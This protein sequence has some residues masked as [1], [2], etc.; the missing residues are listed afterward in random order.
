MLDYKFISRRRVLTLYP[1][2][3]T[4]SRRRKNFRR[5][6]RY[7]EGFGLVCL[8]VRSKAPKGILLESRKCFVFVFVFVRPSKNISLCSVMSKSVSVFEK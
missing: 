6:F 5:L 3:T 7:R 8:L 2:P 4:K 1:S